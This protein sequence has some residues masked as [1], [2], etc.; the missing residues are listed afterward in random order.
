MTAPATPALATTLA[1][2][3]A[4]NRKAAPPLAVNG[5]PPWAPPRWVPPAPARLCRRWPTRHH[6]ETDVA[7]AA[8]VTSS[9]EMMP[10]TVAHAPALP[11]PA[12]PP[13]G[14]GAPPADRGE[15]LLARLTQRRA[16]FLAFTRRR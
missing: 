16:R 6:R 5:P 13:G 2:P 1:H 11:G 14:P 8:S 4:A 12:V 10:M 15:V 3:A 9:L 7:G